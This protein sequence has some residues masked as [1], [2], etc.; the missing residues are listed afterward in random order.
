MVYYNIIIKDKFLHKYINF[1]II[2]IYMQKKLFLFSE[3]DMDNIISNIDTIYEKSRNRQI[4]VLEPTI[5]EYKKNMKII[6]EYIKKERRIIYGGYGWNLLLKKSSLDFYKDTDFADI[7][8]YSNKP[9]YDLKNLVDILHGTNKYVQGKNAQHEETYKIF[10]N[11]INYCDITYMP[12]NLYNCINTIKI[13]DLRIV[14]PILIYV[15]LLRVFTDPITSYFRIEKNVKRSQLLFKTYPLD[16]NKGTYSFSKFDDNLLDIIKIFIKYLTSSDTLIFIGDICYNIYVNNKYIY[17]NSLL[18][19]ISTD[20]KNDCNNI[21]NLLFKYF[22]SKNEDHKITN[23]IKIDQYY[24]FFQYLDKKIIFKYNG[25]PILVLYGANEK[26]IPYNNVNITILDNKYNI[27]IGTFNVY[28]LNCMILYY[29]NII[30]NNKEDKKI[31]EIII[32][33]LI[34]E[35][36]NFFNKNN[37]TILDDTIYKDF[38]V[39]CIGHTVDF[40]RKFHLKI[41]MKNYSST[42]S[43]QTYDPDENKIFNPEKYTFS[44]SSGNIIN[45]PKDKIFKI[46]KN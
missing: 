39:N 22:I 32:Y 41:K 35:R 10:V 30:D 36:N 27:N 1:N 34:T 24:P 15:D 18:E 21:Y 16:F 11:F 13:N 26:C 37:K 45:N 7:E 4:N 5:D 9:I 40:M 44:N 17:P 8:F 42:S 14:D 38:D 33:N 46:K 12:S 28:L 19:V 43:I 31:Y 6:L 23:N 25:T 29:K 2:F 3:N 20:L